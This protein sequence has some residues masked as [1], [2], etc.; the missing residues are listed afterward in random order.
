MSIRTELRRIVEDRETLSAGRSHQPDAAH[1]RQRSLRD[2]A[3]RLPRRHGRTRRNRRRDRR[4]RPDPPRSRQRPSRSP[5]TN[6]PRSSTPAAPAE[7]AAEPSTSP[8]PRRSSPLP[9]E[10][11][12]P[13]TATAPSPPGAGPPTSLRRSASRQSSSLRGCRRRPARYGFCFLLAPA[14]HPAMKSAD[15]HPPRASA[16]APFCT[17][18]DR[19]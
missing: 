15:A 8:P 16:C 6:A 18:S 11:R 2:G 13:S 10:L 17:S 5:T 3:R 19:C 4:L 7:T 14:H 1:S 12:S 9:L